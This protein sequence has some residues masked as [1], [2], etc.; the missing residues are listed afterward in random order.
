M[1]VDIEHEGSRNRIV[2]IDDAGGVAGVAETSKERL[3][4]LWVSA[5]ARDRSL[6]NTLALAAA[7]LGAR[8]ARP[9]S[10]EM[11]GLLVSLGW[12]SSDNVNWQREA[13]A[14]AA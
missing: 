9:G 5:A 3:T 10:E 2:L 11:R 6:Q 13:L 1:K 8:V 14:G 7:A 4:D 12:S